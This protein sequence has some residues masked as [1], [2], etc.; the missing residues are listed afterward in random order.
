[1]YYQEISPIKALQQHV[2][3]F[4]VLED[5]PT[6]KQPQHFKILPDA[7]PALIFQDQ[8]NQFFDQDDQAMPQLY[9]YGQFTQHSEHKVSGKFRIIGAFLEP[10]VLKTLFHL[11]AFELSNQ[12]IALEDLVSDLILEQLVNASSAAEKI[13]II[14]NFIL[15]RINHAKYHDEKARYASFLIQNGKTLPEIQQQMNLSER[16]LERLSKQYIGMSPKLYARI[17]RFQSS[18]SILRHSSF[19]NLSTVAYQSNYF[20][21]SHFIREFKTFTGSSPHFFLQ[22]SEEKLPN[23]PQWKK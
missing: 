8:P 11:D 14:S 12:N 7:L 23:F 5:T 6:F 1:M 3:Y 10:T 4:W 19:H 18:L 16:S 20:D 15:D 21:Q 13:T 9:I 22:N 17:M 2:R